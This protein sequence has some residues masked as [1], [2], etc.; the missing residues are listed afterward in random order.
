MHVFQTV[1][2]M[3]ALFFALVLFPE[4]QTRAQAELDSVISRDRLPTYDDKPRLPYIEAMSKEL[5]R[6]HMVTPMGVTFLLP[7]TAACTNMSMEVFHTR[8]PKTTSIRAISFQKVRNNPSFHCRLKCMIQT[9]RFVG[10]A[11]IINAWCA[12]ITS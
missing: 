7:S 2:L 12:T 1:S 3:T 11:V 5:L 8:Q 4:V 10:A 9:S 6:W